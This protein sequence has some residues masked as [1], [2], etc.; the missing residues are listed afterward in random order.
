MI[1]IS[2]MD[3]FLIVDGSNLLF[4]MF[5]GMPAR[6]VNKDGRAMQGTLGFV[7]AL[8]KIIRQI[9][10]SHVVV[11]FDG[12]HHNERKDIDENYKANRPDFSQ[13][14]EEETPFSQLADIYAALDYLSIKH[15]ETTVCETDDIVAAYVF[16]YKE[17][18]EIVVSSFDS[19]FFQLIDENVQVLRYRGENS[20]LCDK[21]Y[22]QEKFGIE[23]CQYADFKALTGDNADN[24]KG[25]RKIGPK[26]ASALMNEFR[27]LDNLLENVE[28]ISKKC[29]RESVIE[30]KERLRK[31]QRLI[32][33]KGCM[34]VP[35]SI[36][37]LSFSYSGVT[38]NEVLTAIGVK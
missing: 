3:R 27:C 18:G 29:V 24:I 6:I 4:Q 33:L 34:E 10:P 28:K 35:F 21:A 17:A 19:D 26:T 38:T 36:E 5:Y 30:A 20:C 14:P 2:K 23:P 12:E 7:G 15:T 11:L 9:K 37:E 8:L 25:A 13:M 16:R 31:N 1:H 22:L 32:T